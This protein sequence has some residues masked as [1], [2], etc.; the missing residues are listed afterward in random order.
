MRK[1]KIAETCIVKL[2]W[3]RIPGISKKEYVSSRRENNHGQ[4]PIAIVPQ[5]LNNSATH[6]DTGRSVPAATGACGISS[7][8]MAVDNP[9][10]DDSRGQEEDGS[11]EG[12]SDVSLE[13]G[14]LGLSG[15]AVPIPDATAVHRTNVLESMSV[16][17]G[18][19]VKSETEAYVDEQSKRNNVQD[20]EDKIGGPV[21]E[22]GGEWEEEDEREENAQGSHDLRINESLLRPS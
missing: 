13:L 21:E 2:M 5:G 4:P 19:D 20:E 10:T 16:S 14:A 18:L 3:S 6:L 22:A 9:D 8:A 1:T 7:C 12:E 11:Q 17:F 15:N